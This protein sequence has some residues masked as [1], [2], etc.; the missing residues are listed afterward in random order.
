VKRGIAR[1]RAQWKRIGEIVLAYIMIAF[2]LLLAWHC[3]FDPAFLPDIRPEP[4]P[5]ELTF[6][7][8]LK[9]S[10]TD[11]NTATREELIA[12]PRIGEVLADRIIAYRQENGG[13][14][15]IE[16]LTEIKGI[17]EKTLAV[18]EIYVYVEE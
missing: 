10:Y 16:E 6:E 15:S 11:L 3:L 1:R 13:F 2:G 12:L 9:L 5:S 18:L 17:G 8:F 4:L 14:S 7:E